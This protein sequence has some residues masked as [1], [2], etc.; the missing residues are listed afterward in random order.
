MNSVV[1]RRRQPKSISELSLHQRHWKWELSSD[2]D[3]WRDSLECL[4]MNCYSINIKLVSWPERAIDDYRHPDNSLSFIRSG[5]IVR[6]CVNKA[7]SSVEPAQMV[8][9]WSH[10]T[11]STE[12]KTHHNEI[13]E[14]SV[15]IPAILHLVSREK[16]NRV[17]LQEKTSPRR[18]NPHSWG[19]RVPCPIVH[20]S[21]FSLSQTSQPL[22]WTSIS[23][24]LYLLAYFLPEELIS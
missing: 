3:Q 18:R 23:H 8:I 13:F 9:I 2:G 10:L 1:V 14:A 24:F 5:P 17:R 16:E 12:H 4:R 7:I 19:F 20:C 6:R 11:P 22:G 21:Q 15:R